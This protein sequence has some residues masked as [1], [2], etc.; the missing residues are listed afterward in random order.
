MDKA[1]RV[2][3]LLPEVDRLFKH[4]VAKFLGSVLGPGLG[5]CCPYAGVVDKPVS[6]VGQL[7]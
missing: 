7:S 4:G 1:M 6:R 2:I 5:L 3:T